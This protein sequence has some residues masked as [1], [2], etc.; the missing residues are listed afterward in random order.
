VRDGD[1]VRAGD[2]LVVLESMKMELE[3]LAP[4][5]GTVHGLAV[6][7]GDRVSGGQ[8]LVAVGGDGE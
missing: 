2:V 6:A 4:A 5:A 8:L 1:A 3:V 7:A